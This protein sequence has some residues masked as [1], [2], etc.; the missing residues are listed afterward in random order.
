MGEPRRK[1]LGK[2][3]A[4]REPSMESSTMRVPDVCDG[5]NIQEHDIPCYD[6]HDDGFDSARSQASTAQSSP[7]LQPLRLQKKIGQGAFGSVFLAWMGSQRVAVK[8]IEIDPQ[9]EHREL[10]IMQTLTLH[11]H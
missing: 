4:T 10:S 8:R 7:V 2:A 1:I 6:I 3:W 9:F 11:A 5:H